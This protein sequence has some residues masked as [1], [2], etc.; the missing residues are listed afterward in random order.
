[1]QTIAVAAISARAMAEAAAS[2]G[3][4]VVALDL[5]GDVDTRRAASRWMPIG[6]PGSLQIDAASVLAALRTLAEDSEPVQ[7]W[8]AGSGFEGEP[9]LLEEGA[10]VLPLIGTAPAAVRRLRDPAAFFGFLAAQVIPFPQVLL[11]PPEDPA[12]W[13]MKDAHGCG[14]W[15]VR[16]AP[17]SIDE[18][19]S[20]HHYFQRE[21]AGLPMSATFITNGRDVHVLG[22]NEQTVRRFGTRPFVFC[23]AVGPVPVA[24]DIARRVTAIARTLAVE[25]ELRGL[26][27]LDFMRD[28][29]AIGVLEVNPRPPASMSLYKTPPGSPGVMQAHLRACL[30]G[31]L[32]P[33]VPSAAQEVEGIEIVFAREPLQLDADAAQRLAAWPGIRDLPEAGQ[34]FEIDDP[35]CTLTAS[36]SNAQQVRTRLNEGRER[37]L[38]SLETNA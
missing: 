8:I 17:W 13:L 38:Q 15:H 1:M 9:E 18:P 35:V 25:F 3:F 37:L 29:D 5:F 28:G 10:A 6:A 16:H 23:G 7:G 19:P 22:F 20:S 26:C 33:Q 36:G 2:E 4:K 34:R 32:P 24:E 31:E 14:G 21:M 11:Q 27:S 30:H 12:G